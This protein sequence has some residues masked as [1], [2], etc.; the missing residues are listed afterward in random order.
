[1]ARRPEDA[2]EYVGES[3]I[4][5]DKGA[6]TGDRRI[7]ALDGIR[8][9]AILLV[10]VH[11]TG[12][13]DGPTQGIAI[14]LWAVVS[15]AGWTGVQLFFAL[16][17]FLITRILL[18][19]R[20]GPGWMRSFYARRI[21]RIVPLYYVTVAAVLF[22]APHIPLLAPLAVHGER[23]TLWYW[24]YLSN[25]V[26]PFG[27]LVAAFPHVWSLAVEEQFYLLWPLIIAFL[28]DRSLARLCVALVFAAVFARLSVHQ[29]FVEKLASET[30]YFWT[31]TRW[32]TIALGALVAI[33]MRNERLRHE[34]QSRLGL[35]LAGG[36]LALI[37]VIGVVHGLAS[38][39]RVAELVGQPLTGIVSAIIVFAC[40]STGAPGSR[41]SRFQAGLTRA[42]SA[43]WLT[44]IGKYSYAIYI[45]HMP[46]HL[47]IRSRVR[48]AMVR[49][50]VPGLFA[51]TSI[52]LGISLVL[53]LVSW[54]LIERPF[55]S[56]K[57]Y[58][59]TPVPQRPR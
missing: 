22:V 30:N 15:N 1:M 27:G 2:I 23:S 31:I 4:V 34:I 54:W 51:Y 12:T 13:A 32:D 35:L 7:L 53:A 33:A 52:V 11:N 14:K 57:R 10:I 41:T 18:Q 58:F 43:R 45:F 21:L 50:G 24:A 16:S 19:S 20:G 37:A 17:G 55:L 39:G 56:L 29:L 46:V 48:E 47:V 40:V 44:V 3:G 42:L 28:A 26:Y 36:S 6:E 25:W 9:I 59:P 38:E 49:T 8:A 5:G